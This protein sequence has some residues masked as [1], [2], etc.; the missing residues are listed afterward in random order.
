MISKNNFYFLMDTNDSL[1]GMKGSGPN[2]CGDYVCIANILN[3]PNHVSHRAPIKGERFGNGLVYSGCIL[4]ESSNE[5]RA[6]LKMNPVFTSREFY[7]VNTDPA[8]LIEPQFLSTLFWRPGLMNNEKGETE[9]SFY[10][11]DITGK[12]RIVVQGAGITDVI[13]EESSFMVK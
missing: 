5:N 7:G 12:F 3:C 4:E 1:Y 8:G 10:T 13:F 6:I 11:G 2:A 9:F